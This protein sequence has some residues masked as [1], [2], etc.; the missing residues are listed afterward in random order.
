MTDK[1]SKYISVE[2][3]ATL[4]NVST[5]TI[6]RKLKLGTIKSKKKGSKRLVL[7][8]SLG[9][10][11]SDD[12]GHKKDKKQSDGGQ[13]PTEKR[14]EKTT[15]EVEFLRQQIISLNESRN[16]QDA[17][18]AEI[19]QLVL[20]TQQTLIKLNE[21]LQLMS[22]Q[23]VKIGDSEDDKNN[24]N[25]KNTDIMTDNKIKNKPNNDG[26]GVPTR[27][28]KKNA[29]W[30]ILGAFIIIAGLSALVVLNQYGIIKIY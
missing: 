20:N 14:T 25:I 15:G 17:R 29:F 6:Q 13:S 12:V 10:P 4:L 7:F 11:S 2:Q 21:N 23:G 27:K 8:E 26:Q 3:A 5:K 16:K 24:N 30:V 9:L 1:V 22:G 28:N 18:L 19:N